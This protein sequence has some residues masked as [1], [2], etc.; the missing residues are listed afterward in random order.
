M[1]RV[2][3]EDDLGC[4][5]AA[6]PGFPGCTRSHAGDEFV[7]PLVDAAERVLAQHRAPRLVVELQMWGDITERVP[8]RLAE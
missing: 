3:D 6:W 4:R 1:A 7:Y 8:A 2:L 5:P